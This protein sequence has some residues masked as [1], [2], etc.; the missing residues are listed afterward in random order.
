MYGNV[1][2]RNLGRVDKTTNVRSFYA[3]NGIKLASTMKY[4]MAMEVLRLAMLQYPEDAE[5]CMLRARA[6]LA[7][8]H[9]AAPGAGAGAAP[10][11]A[12]AAAEARLEETAARLLHRSRVDAHGDFPEI[13][14]ELL[15][16]AKSARWA[17]QDEPAAAQSAL[18]AAL[19]AERATLAA[20]AQYI[21]RI[22]GAW[23]CYERD[24]ATFVMHGVRDLPEKADDDDSNVE[25]IRSKERRL[26]AR[27]S[28]VRRQWLAACFSAL[29][30]GGDA[31]LLLEDAYVEADAAAAAR[32]AA[33]AAAAARR[34][35]GDGAG[36]GAQAA[37]PPPPTGSLEEQLKA[38]YARHGA[39][40]RA[41]FERHGPTLPAFFRARVVTALSG[42]SAR[43]PPA[44]R[45]V[46]SAAGRAQLERDA[47]A[48][49]RKDEEEA[50]AAAAQAAEA[51]REQA[52]ADKARAEEAAR[53]RR[54]LRGKPAAVTSK[55]ALARAQAEEAA[56][57]RAAAQE[58]RRR[59]E[60]EAKARDID[61]AAEVV[62]SARRPEAARGTLDRLKDMLAA[63]KNVAAA[64]AKARALLL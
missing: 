21:V 37:A 24:F 48:R 30:A 36:A 17:W 53:R 61:L 57:A 18:D 9:G 4:D 26:A 52:A 49:E 42:A 2:A 43:Q 39:N 11:R 13:W 50:A 60:E 25:S 64:A 34:G 55:A 6:G 3:S 7:A 23:A 54:G 27:F 40:L 15:D 41:F 8:S 22:A 20:E 29:R 44:F 10:D 59:L 56:A 51:A 47:D 33:A 63:Q 19:A 12:R 46:L 35:G 1:T 5:W 31:Q 62:Q 32:R 38:F 28:I 58:E 16:D 14:R 45:V